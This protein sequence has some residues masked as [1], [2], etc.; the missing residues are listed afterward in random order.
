[1]Y[2][3]EGVA[4][5][6]VVKTLISDQKCAINEHLGTLQHYASLCEHVTEF[7]VERGN[8]TSAFLLAQPKVLRS[9]D[10]V[11]L[12]C[13][14]ALLAIKGETDF[15]FIQEDVLKVDIEPTDLLFI[16]T[17]HDFSQLY[18]ELFSHAFKVRRYIL[19]HDTESFGMK[20]QHEDMGVLPAIAKFLLYNTE[21]RVKQHYRN[22]NGLTILEKADGA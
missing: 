15:K 14:E 2:I 6:E 13:Y 22:C 4:L 3:Q 5:D 7:G 20:G 10:I 11:P 21:W 17:Y 16:D 19:L 8:S 18:A 12:S 9:Y 1:M